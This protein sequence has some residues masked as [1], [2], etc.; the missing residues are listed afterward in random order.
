MKVCFFGSYVK[1]AYTPILKKILELQEVEVIECR[2]EISGVSSFILGYFRLIFKHQ[3]LDY[4][5]MI[6]P[7]RG[8]IT[9]P[10]AKVLCKKPIVYNS[11]I[12]IYDTL[13][14]DRKK[15]KPNQIHLLAQH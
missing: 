12:S 15:I 4:D 5:V 9:L 3:K 1:A 14:L 6:I 11:G 8:I 7:W 2:E 10:L 13:V